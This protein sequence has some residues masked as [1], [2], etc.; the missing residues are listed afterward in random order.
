MRILI[1]ISAL[2]IAVFLVQVSTG[3]LGPLDALSGLKIGFSRTQIGLLGSAHFLGFIVGCF[4][5]PML[6]RR[7][8]HARTFS[9]VTGLS[10]IAVLL[11]PLWENLYFWMLLRIFSG[12]AVAGASTVI[13]SW[14]N[15]KLTNDNRSRYYSFYRMFDMSGA[16]VA[17]ALIA[18]LPPAEFMAYSLVAIFLCLSFFPLALTKS[19]QP[20][21]PDHV[22]WRPFLA[23]QISPIAVAGVLIVGATGAAIRMV[24]P[25]FAFDSNLSSAQIG[26]FLALFILGGALAQLPVG[27]LA[28]RF[29]KRTLMMALS[30]TTVLVSLIMQFDAVSSLF[31]I[32]RYFILVFVF[33]L[34]TM[35]IY[36]LA[37]THAN[38]LCQKQDMTDL[39]ASL[40]FFFALGA[41]ASPI[42]SGTLIDWYGP[43]ILFLYFA[44]LH[45]VLFVFGFYRVIRRPV[46]HFTKP[47]RYIPR[48]SLFIAKTVKSLRNHDEA[49]VK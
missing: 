16:L 2:L 48:T 21:L 9:F 24:G 3:T 26:L 40:I 42:I 41:I 12:I 13:E 47:Y 5:S 32:Y 6:V 20:T 17:Q 38:D 31:G 35:P 8:G 25:L 45:I 22:K 29:A 37:A 15:A 7:V 14:L 34:A 49:D 28:D 39:S 36:S 43:N 1:S 4:I 27:Y 46:I 18:T 10:I 11:H 30:L 44:I 23:L 33:G 19:V